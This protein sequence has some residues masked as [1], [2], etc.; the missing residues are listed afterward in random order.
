MSSSG[1]LSCNSGFDLLE[2]AALRLRNREGDEH[3]A[4][5]TDDSVAE[6]DAAGSDTASE[7]RERIGEKELCDPKRTDRG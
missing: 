6:K 2:R 4:S 3:A 5:D 7:E 1:A